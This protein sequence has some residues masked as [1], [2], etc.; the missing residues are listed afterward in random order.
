MYSY[1]TA[2]HVQ[3]IP[4]HSPLDRGT[5]RRDGTRLLYLRTADLKVLLNSTCRRT[6]ILRSIIILSYI[7][8]LRTYLF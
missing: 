7:P 2:P 8:Q 3:S 6:G 5:G 1:F 4:Y